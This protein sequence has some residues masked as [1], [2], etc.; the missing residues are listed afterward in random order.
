M[1]KT[2][3][4]SNLLKIIKPKVQIPKSISENE[5]ETQ[6]NKFFFLIFFNF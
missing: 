6:F 4:H 5:N 3:V 2:S 1:N